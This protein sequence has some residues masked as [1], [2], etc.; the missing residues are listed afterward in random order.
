[1]SLLG[2]ALS[3]L[4]AAQQVLNVASQNIA[5]V[6]TPGYSRQEA[7]IHA[8]TD[9]SHGRL[10]P[11]AGVEVT[12]LR[13]IAD[14]YLVASLWRASSQ[15]G[16]D[17]Q[18]ETLLGF[19]EAVVGSEEL[20]ITTGLDSFFAALNAATEAPQ[21]IAA[22]QQILASGGAL[23]S[24]FQQLSANLTLQ[25]RQINEQTAANVATI[26]SQLENLA[27][28]NRK[29][30]EVQ[31]KGGNTS[32]LEDQ[33]DLALG[34]LAKFMEVRTQRYPDGSMSVTLPAGQPLVMTGKAATL[35][36]SNGELSLTMKNQTFPIDSTGGQLGALLDY[37]HNT[38]ADLRTRLNEQAETLATAINDQL[39]QGYDLNGDPGIALFVFEPNGAAG[40]L[41]INPQMTAEQLAFI[42]DDGLGNPVGGAGDNSNLLEVVA[43]KANFYDAY[44]SLVG[45]VAIQSAQIQA[46]ATASNSLL[47]DAQSRRDG[48]SGVNQD[49]EAI[50]LMNF[51]QAYQAN[52]KVV[53]AADQLFNTL[54]GMF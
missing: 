50:K 10:S 2:N 33:R 15:A 37:Q 52:A 23:A 49:E 38:L 17:S 7:V 45:D 26:N 39:Q 36:I 32:Q 46:Q 34:E 42:G 27:L 43:L 54:L 47:Q 21:S 4:T 24:R 35:Q 3:G 53:S 19:A 5:N 51:I 6:N 14:D 8:R 18:T 22:R 11:G 41:R 40:T 28:L 25:E 31:G 13:R 9:G 30:M 44:T 16:Y 48:V 1:M 12:S 29:I 20:G